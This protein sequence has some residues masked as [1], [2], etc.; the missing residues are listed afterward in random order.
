MNITTRPYADLQLKSALF[1]NPRRRNGIDEDEIRELALHIG[2]HDLEYPL[3]I[4]PAGTITGGQ[5]RY[6]A[7]GALID[8]RSRFPAH[9]GA[10]EA[11]LFDVRAAMLAGGVPCIIDDETDPG[12]LAGKA[13]ADNLLHKEMCSYDIAEQIIALV[14]RGDS[15]RKIATSIGRDPS[16]VSRMVSSWKQAVPEL[17]VIWAS[18]QVS[19]D[20]VYELTR[21]PAAEQSARLMAHKPRGSHGRPGVEKLKDLL[22]E[23]RKRFPKADEALADLTANNVRDDPY[24]QAGMIYVLRYATGETSSEWIQGL[25]S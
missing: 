25:L 4:T 17:H 1:E 22:A 23:A 12:V 18:G 16:Y 24:F 20:E 11:A 13:L 8:W 21:L 9:I 14:E 19:F 7:I 10:D 3:R 5:R 2:R 6:H 15:Q